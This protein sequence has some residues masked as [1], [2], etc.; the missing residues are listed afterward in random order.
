MARAKILLV[1]FKTHKLIMA[2]ARIE[3]LSDSPHNIVIQNTLNS[4]GLSKH[5]L[6]NDVSCTC[7]F[8]VMH[9]QW[10]IAVDA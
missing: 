4:Y 3:I 10:N 6:V 2:R 5:S 9:V 8:G 1:S 7:G